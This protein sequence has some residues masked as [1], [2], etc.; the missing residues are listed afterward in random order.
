MAKGASF[1]R[2]ICKKLSLWWTYDHTDDVFW[3]SSQSGGRAT[4]RHRQGKR[5][6]GSYGDICALDPIGEPLLKMF[7]I[8]LKRGR[9][10]GDPADLLDCTGNL[11]KHP[12]LQA[13]RQAQAGAEAAGSTSWLLI[14]KRDFR[15]ACAYFPASALVSGGA[16]AWCQKKLITEPVFRYRTLGE[17]F[18]GMR[19]EKFL[20]NVDPSDLATVAAP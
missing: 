5:T 16:L 15:A 3:R 12:F 6:A 1:E 11:N 14:A 18:I 19:L 8:E 9:S 20:E 2:E 10:H 13:V 4:I 17:D 7:T